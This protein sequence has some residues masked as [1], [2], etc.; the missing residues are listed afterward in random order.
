MASKERHEL[1][2]LLS[3]NDQW[4]KG[5]AAVERALSK[6]NDGGSRRRERAG[7]YSASREERRIG[8]VSRRQQR[9]DEAAARRRRRQAEVEQR[10][11]DQ[12]FASEASR[13]QREDSAEQSR[14]DRRVARGVDQERRAAETQE[15]RRQRSVEAEE[16]RRQRSTEAE[17]RRR[18]RAQETEERR[19]Q[20]RIERTAERSRRED[21]R[22]R[23][24]GGFLGRT[25][26]VAG[27]AVAAGR[28][29]GFVWRDRME[30]LREY[31]DAAV[32]LTRAQEQFRTLNLGPSDNAKAFKAVKDVVTDV[33]GIK[34]SD[35]T[36]DLQGLK[37]VFGD[38]DTAIKMLP[39]A[40][41]TRF[42]F[43]TLFESD[44][45]QLEADILKTMKA[46]EQMGAIRQTPGGGPDLKRFQ[47]YFDT[48]IK[49]KAYTGGRIGGEEMMQFVGK[50]G[51]SAMG[52]SPR[53]LMHM[54]SMMEA[55]G[56]SSVGTSLMSA[57]QSFVA[58][59]QGAGGARSAD[60][61]IKLGLIDK[62]SDKIEWSREGRVK[63]LL[64][65]AMPAAELLGENPIA[66]ADALAAAIQNNG[67]KVLGRQPD[68]TNAGDVGRI[69]AQITGNRKTADVLAKAILMRQNISKDVTAIETSEG[70]EQMFKR[71]NES[72]LGKLQ[73]WTAAV[74]NFKANVG[75][76]LLEL[77][78]SAADK[79]APIGAFFADHP[80]VT[81]WGAAVLVG[82]KAMT[83]LAESAYYLK[84]AGLFSIFSSGGSAAAGAAA[85]TGK[86]ASVW[87]RLRAS[88]AIRLTLT[89]AALG[90]TIE[91]LLELKHWADEK[92]D[93]DTR[94]T[95]AAKGNSETTDKMIQSFRERNEQVPQ[96]QWDSIASV[97]AMRLNKD[98]ELEYAFD[99]SRE[100]L[101]HRFSLGWE[102]PFRNA[103]PEVMQ[104]VARDART[105]GTEMRR[106][107]EADPSYSRF[108]G[109]GKAIQNVIAQ[110]TGKRY[111]QKQAPEL[112]TPELMRAFLKQIDGMKLPEEG[113]ARLLKMLE[114]AFPESYRAV[115]QQQTDETAKLTEQTKA[116]GDAMAQVEQPARATS[117]ALMLTARAMIYFASN[118]SN[119]DLTP[120]D[121]D[122]GGAGTTGAPG[123]GRRRPFDYD[124]LN[125]FS[126]TSGSFDEQPRGKSMAL[127]ADSRVGV[128]HAAAATAAA[129]S[130]GAF[131]GDG[132]A[133]IVAAIKEQGRGRRDAAHVELN[134]YGVNDPR[135]LAAMVAYEL[136]VQQ[137]R[138]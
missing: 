99:P 61:L 48:V 18:Q 10:R 35:L 58:F 90:F 97:A 83:G 9:E 69:L 107:V 123:T 68:I 94:L 17:G 124:P 108:W 59:R 22:Y 96:K 47:E 128:S 77:S 24:N 133:R 16:R 98:R 117:Y 53:G 89:L 104:E 55:M 130:G 6:M 14:I 110:E 41:K 45:D 88:S 60:A 7:E 23:R 125:P 63:R 78:A 8:S 56:G 136:G 19:D 135:E 92:R 65:G 114:L 57:F 2:L 38:L 112:K 115:M 86:L 62:Q 87:T 81:K 93:A 28:S 111:L 132:A 118:L 30:D 1:E 43:Q 79:L 52:L 113:R 101:Y 100:S 137:E 131:H 74:E 26:D 67:A 121:G 15:R 75:M 50:G 76:P 85:E 37:S 129:Q 103:P 31:R 42:T 82:W 33:R 20:R 54:A 34:L 64:P 40:A 27:G 5:L 134:V 119:I 105:P 49:I 51:I 71:A 120:R 12:S 80:N 29:I 32:E 106:R 102:N 11:S 36:A 66:F 127:A 4:S 91:Q 72:D 13:K 25:A 21:A 126:T 95:D 46:L 3:L 138:A 116:A 39:V 73:R 70:P 109:D 122:G 84:G 44:P